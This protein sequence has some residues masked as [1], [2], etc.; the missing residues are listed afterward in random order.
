MEVV[1]QQ[2]LAFMLFIWQLINFRM[3]ALFDKCHCIK[4][5]TAIRAVVEGKRT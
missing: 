3:K 5:N 4:N 2:F 1:Q